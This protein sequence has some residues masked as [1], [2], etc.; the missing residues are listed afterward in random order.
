MK[1]KLVVL[2][3]VGA[4]VLGGAVGVGAIAKETEVSFS[5]AK[6]IATQ[7]VKGSH[8]KELELDRE[9]GKLVYEVEVEGTQDGDSE[10]VINAT[11]GKVIRVEDDRDDDRINSQTTEASVKISI[12]QAISI[13]T[14]DTPGKIV[15]IE[16]DEDGY[17]E[18]EMKHDG[19]EV[20]MEVSAVD[21]TILKKEFDDDND[22]L[23]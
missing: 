16:L 7:E 22:D 15:E 8:V 13:A 5:K 6:E 20:E 14:K 2:G 21:G 12:D 1:K 18:I 4:V 23:R 3:I 17:Y 9:N 11:T 19:K 10:V